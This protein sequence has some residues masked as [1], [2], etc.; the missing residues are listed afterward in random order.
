MSRTWKLIGLIFF[1]LLLAGIALVVVSSMSGGS[2]TSIKTNLAIRDY[3][4]SFTA[5]KVKELDLTLTAGKL[6]IVEGDE[7][8]VEAKNIAEEYFVCEL[9]GSTLIVSENWGNDSALNISRGLNLIDYKPEITLYVPAGHEFSE[10]SLNIAAGSC[11]MDVLTADELSLDI[12][13]GSLSISSL[14]TESCNIGIAAGSADI[15]GTIESDADISCNAGTLKLKLSGE[16][17]DYNFDLNMGV[18]KITVGGSSYGGMAVDTELIGRN[19]GADI[20]ISCNAGE[21]NVS[22]SPKT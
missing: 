20:N 13:A 6:T 1:V 5:R 14:Q 16:Q 9:D 8:R 11:E 21:V 22:F 17:D 2:M 15:R 7:L 4:E 18:G 3:E 19:A 10:V 12:A